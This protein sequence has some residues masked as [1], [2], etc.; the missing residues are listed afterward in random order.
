MTSHF[1]DRKMTD[2][3]YGFSF[4]TSPQFIENTLIA[5]RFLIGDICEGGFQ[6][7][8]RSSIARKTRGNRVP[9]SQKILFRKRYFFSF[10]TTFFSL[11]L[12]TLKVW[13][14]LSDMLRNGDSVAN[15]WLIISW[16]LLCFTEHERKWNM[17]FRIAWLSYKVNTILIF[18]KL[19]AY[20]FISKY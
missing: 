16:V 6:G 18:F 7:W 5:R 11:C 12:S 15:E 2:E 8:S 10:S 17:P 9:L 14:S 1:V 19:L 4:N 13:L 3:H 20:I